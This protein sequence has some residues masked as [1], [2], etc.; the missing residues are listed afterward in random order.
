MGWKPGKFL[1]KAFKGVK[2]V[3]KKIGKGIKKLAG[4]VFGALGKLG[5]LGQL[6]LMF[7][8]VPPIFGRMMGAVGSFVQSV[9]PRV[10]QAFT[11]IKGAA[12]GAFNTITEGIGNGIDRVMNFTQGK[13]FNLS[14]GRTSIFASTK[15]VVDP[16]N[17]QAASLDTKA[18]V[19]QS[20][21]GTLDISKTG[22]SDL[23]M[24]FQTVDSSVASL[25]VPTKPTLKD[26][27]ENISTDLRMG[28]P[29]LA[30]VARDAIMQGPP[31]D[32]ILARTT[33]EKTFGQRAQDYISGQVEEFK[34]VFES[35]GKA[36][37][38]A[39]KQGGLQGL[40]GATTQAIMGDPP[41]Q[42]VRQFNPGD[43]M[44]PTTQQRL[45]D[46]ATWNGVNNAYQQAG[47]YGGAAG[48]DLLGA[49]YNSSFA[50]D[51]QYQQDMRRLGAY[52]V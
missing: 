32:S 48:G 21:A 46:A 41:T 6:A 43:Y 45:L 31:P 37:G 52:T 29:D 33:T 35:P 12:Q 5:P 50:S 7:I 8:G 22:A 49:F 51:A 2:K 9:A 44:T 19:E 40:S 13:G 30:D 15:P 28:S 3:A 14:E 1:K 25:D 39:I 16:I 10:Y 20:K 4:K 17:A 26:V 47:A 23:P 27:A 34:Q 38:E 24:E 11:A 36:A 42:T 18:I